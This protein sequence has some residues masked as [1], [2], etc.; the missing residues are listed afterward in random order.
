MFLLAVFVCPS[1]SDLGE[2]DLDSKWKL[3][4]VF[5]LSLNFFAFVYIEKRIVIV[6]LYYLHL[7]VE[8][9]LNGLIFDLNVALL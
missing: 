9:C 6:L 4:T 5:V 7:S 2:L 8:Q 3:C 1:G